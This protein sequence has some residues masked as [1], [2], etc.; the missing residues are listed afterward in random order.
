[1]KV[2]VEKIPIRVPGFQF[3]GVR[4]GIK[5]SGK[6]DIA[7]IC[8]DEPA[9]AAAAFTTSRVKAA[10]VLIG[11]ERSA[12]G[13]LHAI[14][15]NSGNANA[16]TGRDGLA[17]ARAMCAVVAR[18]LRIDERL[19]I[20]SSTGR[21]GVPVPRRRVEQG[22]R[23]ACRSLSREGFHAA[24]EGM[25]TTD[26]FPKF[27][28][29]GLVID[30]RDVTVVGM[31]KGAGMIAP[32]MT[33]VER[34]AA[35]ATLLAYVVTDAAVPAATLRRALHIALPQSFN[36]AVVDGDTST[37]DTVVLMANGVAGNR[38]L[39]PTARAFPAFCGAVTRVMTTLARFVVK[40]GEGATKVIDIRVHGARTVRD[41]ERAA[42]TVARSPLCKTAFFG[43]DPYSGRIIVALG[44]SGAVFEPQKVDVYLDDVQVVRRGQEI[45]GKVERRAAAVVGHPEFTLT[46]HLHAGNAAAHRIASDLTPEYVRFNSSYRT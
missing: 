23:Q 35:H 33:V 32:R 43:G 36:A 15:V 40:D 2:H 19:V 45:V 8:A 38:P 42:D 14:V 31:A 29:E 39:T 20:P 24:L 44:Y 30:G 18:E 28:T 21:V 4:C 12:G 22:V 27:A 16:Y 25:M 3:A 11:M 17:V 1:M 10:P 26:A 41:A 9:A 5:E 6:R 46:I 13:R 37:N 34:R 7:L